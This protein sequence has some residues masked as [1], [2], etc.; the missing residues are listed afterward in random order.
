MPAGTWGWPVA[1]RRRFAPNPCS[2]GPSISTWGARSSH[3]AHTGRPWRRLRGASSAPC[4]TAMCAWPSRPARSW[5][6][7][8]WSAAITARR[9]IGSTF[10]NARSPPRRGRRGRPREASSTSCAA[11][12][13]PAKEG[14]IRPRRLSPKDSSRRAIPASLISACLAM[15]ACM[16]CSS[17]LAM[18]SEPRRSWPE[19]RSPGRSCGSSRPRSDCGMPPEAASLA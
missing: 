15:P 13:L 19:S 5:S 17:S 12:P 18:P 6:T 4:S 1:P 8:T 10:S 3:P 9:Y 14:W 2:T 7:S 11:V 16:R